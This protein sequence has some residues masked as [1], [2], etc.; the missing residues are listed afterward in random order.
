[1]NPT[2]LDV[3]LY[4]FEQ[5]LENNE[6]PPERPVL[7]GLLQATGFPKFTVRQALDWLEALASQQ[8]QL[9][10]LPP[11]TRSLRIFSPSE[12]RRLEPEARGLILHLE[13]TGVID[14]ARRE[15]VIE[16]LVALDEVS[17]TEEVK[18]VVLLTLFRQPGQEAAFARMEDMLYA[19]R[20]LAH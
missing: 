14:A 12:C 11:Q 20:E 2:V 6:E 16:R 8:E 18:W 10:T 1:M 5:H 19:D 7:E 4:L 15:I 3:L 17:G 13:Q 9:S